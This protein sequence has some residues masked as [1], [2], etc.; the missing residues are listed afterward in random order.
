M[1]K[2]PT[3]YERTVIYKIQH[4]EKDELLYVGSTTEFTKRKC[5]HKSDCINPKAKLYN[6]KLYKMIRE[7]GGWEMFNMVI[8]QDFPCKNKREAECEEDKVIREMKASMNAKRA[9]LNAEEK[10]ELKNKS[11]K[12]WYE[13]NKDD[14]VIKQKK[15]YQE[16]KSVVSEKGKI[17]RE[18]NKEKIRARK[19]A[20]YEARKEKILEKEKEYYGANKEK[21]KQKRM[22]KITCEC[23]CVITKYS[24]YNHKKS[25]KHLEIMINK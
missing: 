13:A 21:I 20:D 19:K 23:G 2:T 5:K 7:N 12:Q 25:Q 15:W 10:K 9:F 8:I 6:A 22:E 3:D 14:Q 11:T 18:L 16:N 17:Y 4:L 24:L 1:P